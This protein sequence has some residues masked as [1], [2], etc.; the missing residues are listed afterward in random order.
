[1]D[2]P[3][4][5]TLMRALELLN[6][7]GALDDEGNLTQ[8]GAQMAEF[9]LDPQLAKMLISSVEFKCSNEILSITSMLSVPNCFVRPK[10]VQ[11]QADEGKGRFAHIDGDHLTLLNVYH[12]YKQYNED[13]KWCY[14]N[15]INHRSLKSADSVRSQLERIMTRLHLP[16]ESTEFTSKDYYLNIRKAIL[17]GYFMQVAHLEKLGHYLT[18]KDNQIVNL[19]PG[20]TLDHKPE[21]VVYNEFVLTS[22][23][24]IRTDSDIKGEWL[25]ELAPHYYDLLNFPECE[26]KRTLERMIIKKSNQ[27]TGKYQGRG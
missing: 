8:L 6:Y 1:M 20:T 14:D 13:P 7:L 15:F 3:A 11:K 18:I 5:E 12:A 17:N 10:D 21:W 22:K 4:P 24:F 2:P 19:H 23:N 25:L 26:A 16:L 9:P 27:N